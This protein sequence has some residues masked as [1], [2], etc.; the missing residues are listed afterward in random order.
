MI[1]NIV[2][3]DPRIVQLDIK[4]LELLLAERTEYLMCNKLMDNITDM[5]EKDTETASNNSKKLMILLVIIG[6]SLAILIGWLLSVSIS[7]PL[8]KGVEMMQELAKGHLNMRLKSNRGDE[9]GLLSNAMDSFADDL[10][11]IIIG[12][13]QKISVGDVSTNVVPK[14]TQDEIAPALKK[15]ID[16]Q[17]SFIDGMK[18]MS[19]QHNAG[20]IDVVIPA[21]KFE[22]SYRIMA[23]GVNDMVMSHITVKK[24][25]LA[26]VAEFGKGNFEAPLEKFPGKQVFINDTVETVRGNLKK[27]SK[28]VNELITAIQDGKL[29]TRGRAKEF[30][31][32]WATLVEAINALIE[33]F[34]K[35]INIT[36]DYIDRISKGDIPPKIIDTYN[37]DFN[38][39]K[40]NLNT[41]IEALDNLIVED[42]GRV[43]TAAANKDLTV[44]MNKQ[45]QGK[46]ATMKESINTLVESLNSALKQV[47]DSSVMLAS[48]S[49]QMSSVS[50]Q[51]LS[52]SE[53]TLTQST[54]VASTTEQMSTNINTMASAAEEMSVNAQT[55]A[56][57]AEQMSM[58]MNTVSAAVEEMSVSIKDI[59]QNSKQAR[60]V[61]GKAVAMANNATGTMD[62]L[63]AA[64]K[65]IGKV[66]DVIKRIAEQTN[67]LALNA[68]IEAAS[69]GEAGKGFAVVANEIKELAN[70]SAQ[71]AGDIAGRI[72]GIQG[73]AGDAVKVISDISTIINKI[74]DSVET[75]SLSVEQQTKA[76]ND[77]SAN[78]VQAASG[79]KNIA[80]SITEVSKGSRDVSKNAGEAAKGSRDVASNIV[81]V[82]TASKDSSN[83]AQQVNSSA[84]DLAK[85]AGM[86]RQMVECFKV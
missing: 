40:N 79:S 61:S 74:G 2:E 32:D 51:L 7:K 6:S 34:V 12:T 66:T 68:T 56:S 37:G 85:M 31:G 26:C 72:E 57:A 24:K 47:Q 35:P 80:I 77:I 78:V 1:A 13:M 39:I 16:T 54:T 38:L 5:N 22:G 46:F 71:A 23:Q 25:A 75:I 44:R 27:I 36:S 86:L 4:I 52:N 8:G 21:E 65:E 73:N 83:G 10:Q 42:G 76:S 45:Y 9:I 41:C 20:D 29:Q 11:K 62:K 81:N 69:A 48:A 84:K 55:V 70:Q 59:S 58:N 28:E 53:E 50:T 17:R 67:L 49:E 15:I 60:D 19:D 18:H 30:N 33:A 82:S 3:T 43:L 63:G 14:D 64:A